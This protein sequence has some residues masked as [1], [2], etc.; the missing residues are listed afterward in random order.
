MHSNGLIAVS[1]ET[2][3]QNIFADILIGIGKEVRH[4]AAIDT[5]R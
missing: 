5:Q 2:D 4:E 1:R 3:Y